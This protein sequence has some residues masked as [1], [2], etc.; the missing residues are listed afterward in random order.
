MRNTDLKKLS[1][2]KDEFISGFRNFLY[3]ISGIPAN[4]HEIRLSEKKNGEKYQII[5]KADIP[6]FAAMNNKGAAMILERLANREA[7][8]K[9]TNEALRNEVGINISDIA[10][11]MSFDD[12]AHLVYQQSDNDEIW[13]KIIAA[14]L[15]KSLSNRFIVRSTA[16]FDPKRAPDRHVSINTEYLVDSPCMLEDERRHGLM[17]L[18]KWLKTALDQDMSI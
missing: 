16:V 1:T 15:S 12:I 11:D 7:A 9:M 4:K 6:V 8:L 18:G 2:F 14:A 5:A 17:P 3:E 13:N 10:D